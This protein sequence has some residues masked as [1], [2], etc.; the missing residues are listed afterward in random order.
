MGTIWA[1]DLPRYCEK[2]NVRYRT[3]HGAERRARST[4]GFDSIKGVIVHHTA[5]NGSALANVLR[6]ETETSPNR[7]IGN[8]TLSRDKDGPVVVLTAFG[9][10]NTAGTGGP[11]LSHRGVI[12]KDSANRCTYNIEAQNNGVG[13][14]WGNDQQEMYVRFVCAVIDWANAST[15]GAPLNAG[16]VWSHFEWA[17]GRKI[18]PSGP[19]RWAKN[20]KWDMNAFRGDVALRLLGNTVITPPPAATGAAYVIK[21]GESLWTASKALGYS[22]S[23]L[24]KFNNI[25]NA[26]LV[27]IGQVI[28]APGS[29]GI[30]AAPTGLDLVLHGRTVSRFIWNAVP[31]AVHYHVVWRDATTGALVGEVAT[32]E[33]KHDVTHG[34]RN[35]MV[36]VAA[37]AGSGDGT[38]AQYFLAV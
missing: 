18:D 5:D 26:N 2:W 27:R 15:Q 3:H 16:D 32:R 9:A 4:G 8:A 30:P 10:S 34:G 12:A 13:E 28:K 14:P 24:A 35:V 6:W 29:V 31:G 11:L 36:S 38:V 7:P 17:P 33:L 22:I 1:S 37:N 25:V 19:S 23:E 21:A 20:G